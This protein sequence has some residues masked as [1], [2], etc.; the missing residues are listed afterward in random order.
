MSETTEPPHYHGHRQR[1]RQRFRTAGAGALSEY[2]LMELVLFRAVPQR[3]V[4]ELAGA[5]LDQCGAGLLVGPV[6]IKHLQ[7]VAAARFVGAL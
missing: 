6:R 3:D 7:H 1:L 4:K 5:S 2:E